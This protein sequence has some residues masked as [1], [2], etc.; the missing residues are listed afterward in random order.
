MAPII[1]GALAGLALGW[2]IAALRSRFRYLGG[3]YG[4]FKGM[5]CFKQLLLMLI[6]AAI[7]A[8]IGAIVGSD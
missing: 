3:G 8:I 5:G 7:G 2:L 4:E 1:I 6:L